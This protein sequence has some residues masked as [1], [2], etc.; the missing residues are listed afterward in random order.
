LAA[1]AQLPHLFAENL[2]S[3]GG[4]PGSR[5]WVPDKSSPGPCKELAME[6]EGKKDIAM[7]KKWAA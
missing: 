3:L 2:M 4:Q 7:I 1:A 5:Q 6:K